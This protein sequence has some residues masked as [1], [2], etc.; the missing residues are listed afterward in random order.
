MKAVDDFELQLET[1]TA[2]MV[3]GA[4]AVAFKRLPGTINSPSVLV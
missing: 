1:P 2:T 3:T 4:E